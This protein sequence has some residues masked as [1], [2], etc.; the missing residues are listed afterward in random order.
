MEDIK[1]YAK[2]FL[3]LF[4]GTGI[5]YVISKIV[6][7][8]FIFVSHHILFCCTLI[9]VLFLIVLFFKKDAFKAHFLKNWKFYVIS[10]VVYLYVIY[11][12]GA[13]I[14]L[15]K[16]FDAVSPIKIVYEE[17]S[18][19]NTPIS[20]NFKFPFWKTFGLRFWHD[21]PLY[22]KSF[23]RV[24][25]ML[26][27][28]FYYAN[29]PPKD[30]NEEMHH[31]KDIICIFKNLGEHSLVIKKIKNIIIRRNGAI[32]PDDNFGQLTE[33]EI[34]NE[35]LSQKVVA[36]GLL[37]ILNYRINSTGR[38]LILYPLEEIIL[39]SISP[40]CTNESITIELEVEYLEQGQK[41]IYA[42]H[43]IDSSGFDSK[44]PRVLSAK[45]EYCA[46]Y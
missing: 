30:D 28:N 24:H 19:S 12:L 45:T 8:I 25:Y 4:F 35:G 11:V 15:E 32:V 34:G 37:N 38:P 2:I 14:S 44:S 31:S 27:A 46:S 26:R 9:I 16:I 29:I 36:E 10:V 39:F 40:A 6:I 18:K 13:S 41:T 42:Y 23:P 7:G 20:L 3:Y 5:A 21:L 22:K 17:T 33:A 43:Q 1:K